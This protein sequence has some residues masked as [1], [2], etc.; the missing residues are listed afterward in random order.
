M[1]GI[2][3]GGTGGDN[4]GDRLRSVPRSRSP[5]CGCRYG[6]ECQGVWDP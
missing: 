2:K 4:H 6:I 1:E 5:K 3:G